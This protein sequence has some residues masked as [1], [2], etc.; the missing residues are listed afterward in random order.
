MQWNRSE[1]IGTSS[2]TCTHCHGDGLRHT[3]RKRLGSIRPCN[4][5]LRGVFRACYS[6]FRD[7]ALK[8]K[9]LSRATLQACTGLEGR[10]VWGRKDEEYMADFLSVSRR[11]LDETEHE[12]FRYHFLLGA[13]WRLCCRK[14][15]IDR[16]NF[17]HSVYRI[18]QKLGRVFRELKPYPLFPLD[19][20]FGGTIR[21][22][23]TACEPVRASNV[24][25]MPSRPAWKPLRPPLRE[26][27]AA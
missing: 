2:M 5:T 22:Q 15:N 13:D 7:C 17:F 12:I 21:R 16:G 26:P 3:T 11:A 27:K 4:C 14:L 6:R 10:R 25:E 8:P 9:H 23:I 24:L 1:A 18:Q 20:Y 19:E